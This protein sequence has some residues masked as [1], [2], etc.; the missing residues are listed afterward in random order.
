M[1]PT[2]QVNSEPI[3]GYRMTKYLGRGGVGE[4]WQVEAPGKVAKAVKLIPLENTEA[5]L[6]DRELQGLAKIRSIRHPYLLSIDRYEITRGYVIIVM[7][8]ADKSLAD[9]FEECARVHGT[10]VPRDELLRYMRETAEV[11]DLLAVEHQL[12]HLDIKPE[13]LFMMSGHIKVADFGLVHSS[14]TELAASAL[15]F[16]PAYAPPELFSGRISPSAD[17]YSLAVTYQELLTGRRPFDATSFRELVFAHDNLQPDFS[18]APIEDRPVLL[19]AM[20][21]NEDERYASCTA[22]IDA[23]LKAGKIQIP[24]GTKQRP[25]SV[26]FFVPPAAA[27]AAP[28]APAPHAVAAAAKLAPVAAPAASPNGRS[29]KPMYTRTASVTGSFG[30]DPSFRGSPLGGKPLEANRRQTASVELQPHQD[31]VVN[32][33]VTCVAPELYALKMR[34]FID[35]LGADIEGSPTPNDIVLRFRPNRMVW[36]T[37]RGESLFLRVETSGKP[38]ANGNGLIQASVYSSNTSIVGPALTHKAMLLVRALRGFLMASEKNTTFDA[39][40]LK[41][42]LWAS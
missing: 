2:F 6:S 25:P 1:T 26:Q 7:E 4:V 13:N 20:S 15:A 17:Q 40:V 30:R 42:Q 11:L 8:L 29:V 37:R 18:S 19:K 3:P 5:L 32:T 31:K 33:F 12:Q 9:R 10:G 22:F 34:A 38:G 23:L 27:A 14:M 16:T 21:K 41:A 35:A 24:T 36:F 39:E 28:P